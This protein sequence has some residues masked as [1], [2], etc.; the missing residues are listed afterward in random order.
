MGIRIHIIEEPI[1]HT[2]Y[3]QLPSKGDIGAVIEFFGIVRK[4]ENG[5][6]I[7]GIE[8]ESFREMAEYQLDLLSKKIV[9]KYG[10]LDFLCIHRVGF[11]EVGQPSLFIR[12]SAPHRQE[13]FDAIKEFIAELKKIVPIWKH[14]RY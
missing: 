11:V 1:E 5:G 12:A 14:P 13:V 10:I 8:Y 3:D 4:D 2:R 7:Q 6:H 9:T